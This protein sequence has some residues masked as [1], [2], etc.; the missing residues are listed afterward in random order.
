[1]A[2]SRDIAEIARLFT[3]GAEAAVEALN[4]IGLACPAQ[5]ALAAE[6]ASTLARDAVQYGRGP[7]TP[8]LDHRQTERALRD[9]MPMVEWITNAQAAI[10]D[11][12]FDTARQSLRKALHALG[13]VGRRSPAI[14]AYLRWL[15]EN[16]RMAAMAWPTTLDPMRVNWGAPDQARTEHCSYCGDLLDPDSV[17]LILWDARG[18]CAE[19]CDHC[20]AMHWG[21]HSVEDPVEPVDEP[22]VRH[23]KERNRRRP[24]G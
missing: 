12:A 16:T 8:L 7:L 20:Q 2:A 1:M 17:P 6:R 5:L 23:A 22:E 4:A 10:A 11:G 13:R 14:K 9:L 3:E 21:V 18:W 15:E 19:F 24:H